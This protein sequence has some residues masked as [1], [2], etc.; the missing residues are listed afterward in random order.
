MLGVAVS[1]LLCECLAT[2]NGRQTGS[3]L[4]SVRLGHSARFLNASCRRALL[5]AGA[6]VAGCPGKA[7]NPFRL[8][9]QT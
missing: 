7:G 4:V 2:T 6:S 5:V 9:E 3:L 8:G 1:S